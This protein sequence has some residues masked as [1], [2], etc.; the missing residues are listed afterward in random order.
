[1]LIAALFVI[2]KNSQQPKCVST[3][4]KHTV[5]YPDRQ[6]LL[7]PMRMNFQHRQ[8]HKWILKQH[9]AM[10][11]HPREIKYTVWYHLYQVQEQKTLIDSHRK[12]TVLRVRRR[13][14]TAGNTRE[15][16]GEM[17]VFW[18]LTEVLITQVLILV[19]V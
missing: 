19:R 15:L 13:G 3:R 11:K 10:Q 17:E 8:R 7:N 6:I 18:I 16:L 1:M 12:Q 14:L 5:K 4:D 9:C 2:A